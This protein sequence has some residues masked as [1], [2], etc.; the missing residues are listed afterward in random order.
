MA[1]GNIVLG[2]DFSE[3]SAHAASRVVRLPV[4]RGC[5]VTLVHAIPPRLP[6]ALEIAF[7]RAAQRKLEQSKAALASA[8][9]AAE[10]GD[11]DVFAALDVGS[12]VDIVTTL[13]RDARAALIVVGRGERPRNA[14]L[15]STAERIVRASDTPVLVVARVAAGPYRRPL[16]AVD[17]TE[18]AAA[19]VEQTRRTCPEA[20]QLTV[21]H[22]YLPADP[23]LARMLGET[24]LDKREIDEYVHDAEREAREDLTVRLAPLGE[25]VS[26]ELVLRPGDPRTVV[27]EE[28]AR[29]EVDVIGV[30]TT[31][32]SRLARLLL[33]SVSQEVVRAA[34]CDV[35]VVR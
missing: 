10:R 4:G 20:R 24:G 19:I 3:S 9:A 33:G 11:V 28:A 23:E 31:G 22:G 35:L 13:A 30:G 5:D 34:P 15:G 16:A 2:T 26:F 1:L 32:H 6:E 7:R 25:G 18:L 17:R 8:L 29:R 21:V 27:L 14:L 12:P